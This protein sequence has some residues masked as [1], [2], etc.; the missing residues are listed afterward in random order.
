MLYVFGITDGL[1]MNPGSSI[2]A[3]GAFELLLTFFI[4]NVSLGV[5]NLLPIPPL[6]GSKVLQSILPE[7]FEAGF[8]T[9]ERFGFILLFIAV[10][11]GVLGVVFNVVMP[12]AWALVF[13]GSSP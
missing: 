7:S 11:T 9:L 2:I 6:D 10:F 13:I 5:F 4:L 3:T 8:E 12:I 1:E